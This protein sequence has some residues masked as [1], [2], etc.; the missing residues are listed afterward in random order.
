MSFDKIEPIEYVSFISHLYHII[1]PYDKLHC[2]LLLTLL[3]VKL[4]FIF[5]CLLQ[6]SLEDEAGCIQ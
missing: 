1:F 5:F 3:N 2:F 4:N 6:V